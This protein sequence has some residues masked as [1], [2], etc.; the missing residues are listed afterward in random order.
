MAASMCSKLKLACKWKKSKPSLHI[1]RLCTQH[2]C[3][4][5]EEVAEHS[6]EIVIP[7]RIERGPTDILRAL[8]STVARDQTAAHYKYHDDPFFIPTSNIAKRSYALSKESGRKAAHWISN[9]YPEL[10]EGI[11]PADPQIPVLMPDNPKYKHE[12]A[13]EE[14]V[15]ERL[16]YGKPLVAY[17]TYQ[18][19]LAAGVKLSADARDRLLAILCYYNSQDPPLTEFIEENWYKRARERGV[20]K[21]WKDQG[22]ADQLFQDMGDE[23]TCTSYKLIIRGMVKYYQVEK[24]YALFR[25]MQDKGFEVDLS[26]YNAILSIANFLREGNEQKLQLAKDLMLQMETQDI[27]PDL[28]TINA[29]LELLSKFGN[30][31][32][33]RGQS[34][35][36]LAEMKRLG[37][38]PSLGSYY[39]VLMTWCKDKGPISTILH[40]IMKHIDNKDLTIRHLSDLNFFVAAMDVCHSHLC[41][42]RLAYRVHRLV[43]R[44]NNILLLGDSFKQ[45]TYYMHFF[46]LLCA[47]ESVEKLFEYYEDLVPNVYTPEPSVMMDVIRNL[48]ANS[49]LEHLPRVW[50]D[51]IMFDMTQREMLLTELLHVMGREKLDDTQLM[52]RFGFI[53]W[54]IK[55]RIDAKLSDRTYK[56]PTQWTGEMVGDV[57]V[58][59]LRAAMF[60]QAWEMLEALERQEHNILGFP[61]ERVMQELVEACIEHADSRRAV[62]CITVSSEIGYPETPNFARQVACKLKLTDS[63]RA[64]MIDIVGSDALES[65]SV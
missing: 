49:A 10:F 36:V 28:T 44:G 41:D 65:A 53:A 50:S 4:A 39:F 37:I 2:L 15:L 48:D 7:D 43:H 63:E 47:T 64:Q 33:A 8:A 13:T 6:Q 31:K 60:E 5:N 1:L 35:S 16:D 40:D 57:I 9:Q 14:A 45:S 17:Q 58:V 38:E 22:P 23:R 62:K 18:D 32:L 51:M 29:V 59:C 27:R 30:W 3:S 24:A 34:L 46:R 20:R 25:E 55:T 21:S 19:C 61:S 11:N 54:D 12:G 56:S 52:E 42:M 26:T